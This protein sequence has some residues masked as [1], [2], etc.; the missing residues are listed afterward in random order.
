MV[1]VLD[2]CI[3]LRSNIRTQFDYRN[4]QNDVNQIQAEQ[5]STDHTKIRK[6]SDAS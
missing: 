4:S 6:K 5:L 2:D 3:G 1:I